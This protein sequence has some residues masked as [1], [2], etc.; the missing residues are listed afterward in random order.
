MQEALAL[1]ERYVFGAEPG[2]LPAVLHQA[3]QEAE[4]GR[5]RTRLAAALARCWAYAGEPTRAAEFADVALR[6]AQSTGEPA[7]VADALDAS[8]AAHWSVDD[9]A[10]RSELARRLDDVTAH[11]TQP[12]LRLRSHLWLLTTACEALDVAG[13]NRQM[14]ALEILGEESVRAL[15]FAASRRL[16]LDLLRGRTDTVDT[17]AALAERAFAEVDQPDGHMVLGAMRGY[18][19]VIAGDRATAADLAAAAE[20]IADAEGIRELYAESAWL[21]LG[22]GEPDRARELAERF[23][24]DVLA[25]LPRD[26]NYLLTLQLLLEVALATD[27]VI[28]VERITPLLLPYQ[29][30]AVINAGAVMFHGTTDDTLARALATLGRGNEAAGLRERALATYRSIGATWWRERLESW[31]APGRPKLTLRPGLGGVW[32]VGSGPRVVAVPA[33]RGLTYLHTLVT[34]PGVEISAETMVNGLDGTTQETLG[35]LLDERAIAAYRSRL[36]AIDAELDAA[37][38]RGDDTAAI[39]LDQERR[40][41]ITELSSATGLGGRRRA[42]GGSAERARVAVKKAI[43]TALDGLRSADPG[44][45]DHLATRVVTGLFCRYER[46]PE[47]EWE[48]TPEQAIGPSG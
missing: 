5:D 29:G 41:L 48:T 25:A 44:L 35:P 31:H 40:A 30:R 47:V 4:H 16:M 43:T 42:P 14:R 46:L 12:D 26:F 9:L 21:W 2:R 34:S 19:A 18:G 1:A 11:V 3:F 17:L 8:L 27:A 6:D 10:L 36:V 28:L 13:M 39:R 24:G 15:G 7:L 45:A 33:R 20:E 37:D 32:L 23:D 38:V 22:G